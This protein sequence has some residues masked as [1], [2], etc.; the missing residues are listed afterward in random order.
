[1]DVYFLHGPDRKVPLQDT[2]EGINRLHKMGKFRRF[3][4]SNFP[5]HE[6]IEVIRIA[7]ENDFVQ[8]SV[9][10][11]LY[12]AANR[13]A[14]TELFPILRKHKISFYAYSP[15]AGG[16]LAKTSREV[17]A[18]KGRFNKDL[19]FFGQLYNGLYNNPLYLHFLDGFSRIAVENGISQAELA[20]RWVVYHS[21]LDAEKGDAIIIGARFGE[22]LNATVD[23]LKKGPLD[24]T[25]SQSLDALWSS[26][27]SEAFL[28]NFDGWI[29][30][31]LSS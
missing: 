30:K 5:P 6:V 17:I 21:H 25:L 20:H 11:G 13:K 4:L 8:P 22:Q 31:Q 23:W 12:N 18:G 2:L 24:K 14:E 9:Y 19:G 10:E 29:E 1:M 15:I 26:I 7:Q 28:D 27:A 16:F 3:G